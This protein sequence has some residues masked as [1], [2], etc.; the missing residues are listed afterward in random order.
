MAK[1]GGTAAAAGD[2]V[3]T[4]VEAARLKG[5]SYHTASRA[6]RSGKL[7]HKRVGRMA[8]VA[9]AD[10]AAWRPMIE[11]RPH[12]YAKREPD[13]GATPALID[14]ASG[15]RVALARQL[16]TL[17]E[18]LH[19]AAMAQPLDEFLNLLCQRLSSALDL[20]RT[21]LWG[22][23]ERRERVHRLAV[24][25]GLMSTLGDDVSMEEAAAFAGLV[26][27]GVAI[28]RDVSELGAPTEPLLGV[29]SIFVAPLRIGDRML[30]VIL[31]DR[32][33]APF[34]LS[35]E[36]LLFAQ[37]LA[38]QAAL[39]LEVARLRGELAARDGNGTGA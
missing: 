12:R 18:V 5:V 16:A 26:E 4:L 21:S 1:D 27:A 39:A 24:C 6:V 15:D 28:V 19:G 8:F 14:L 23:D 34:S 30:G 20:A 36:Q 33:G 31:G 37:A 29:T 35:D 9:A 3:Y 32:G 38:N 7:P 11:R 13:P 22:V 10:L 2:Q 25:G 17:L